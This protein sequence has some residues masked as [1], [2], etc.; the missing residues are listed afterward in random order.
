MAK[1][2][3]VPRRTHLPYRGAILLL[4]FMTS[5]KDVVHE[6]PAFF[7]ANIKSTNLRSFCYLLTF[8]TLNSFCARIEN[9]FTHLFKF[10]IPASRNHEPKHAIFPAKSASKLLRPLVRIN[11]ARENHFNFGSGCRNGKHI[12]THSISPGKLRVMKFPPRKRVGSARGR[13]YILV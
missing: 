3:H 7:C 10:L 9:H 4:N 12:Y 8:N 2:F 6:L 5:K 11:L 13:K 1:T